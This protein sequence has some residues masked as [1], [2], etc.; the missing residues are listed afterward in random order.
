[1]ES[2][3]ENVIAWYR[4]TVACKSWLYSAEIRTNWTGTG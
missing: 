1:M 3:V 4:A 2:T